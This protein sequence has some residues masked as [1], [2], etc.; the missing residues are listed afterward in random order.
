MAKQYAIL[1]VQKCKG[2]AIGAMQYHNDREPGKHTN[3]D[4]DQTRT[5][6]N[7]EMR[8]HVDYEREVQAR[9]DEGYSGERKV[10]KDAVKLVEGIVTASPEFFELA[11]DDKVREFFDDAYR[12]C[13]DE[14]GESNM[15]HF[16]VHMDEETPHA[17]FGFVPLRDGKLSWKE[18]FPNKMALGKM[19]DRF[20]GRVGAPYGLS[21]GEKRGDGEPV[22]RHKSVAEYKAESR[23]IQ[24]ELDEKTERLESAR[25]ELAAANDELKAARAQLAECRS[26]VEGFAARFER[27]KVELAQIAEALS[28]R[29]LLKRFRD[30]LIEFSENPICWDA[31]KAGRDFESE[32]DGKRAERVL[33]KGAREKLKEMNQ[34]EKEMDEWSLFD[35]VEEGRA[36]SKRL[37]LERSGFA[38]DRNYD[39]QAL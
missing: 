3:P 27:I 32:K 23:R 39:G 30:K 2:A 17:H 5:R 35:D 28:W 29:N 14:F 31:L 11:D 4:I 18:F 16:T 10:R 34:L 6:L 13:C 19:Q 20:Y 36:A 25:A 9:I 15:V 7:R 12:F 26:Q 22:R 8:S 1:R 33:E 38:P 24:A 37:E 21:R